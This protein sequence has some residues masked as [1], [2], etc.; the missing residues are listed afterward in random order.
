MAEQIKIRAQQQGDIT[1]IRVLMQ[2]P[3]ETGQRKDD[4]GQTLAVNFIQ[5][6]TVS[7]NGKRLIDG[8]LNTSVSKNPLFGFKARGIK[9]GD[10][11]SVSWLD[12]LGDSRQD[13]ITVA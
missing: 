6:F 12:N 13:E 7:H 2:H 5:T 8:Q 9:P 11:I 1:E 10:R 3:M 4:R